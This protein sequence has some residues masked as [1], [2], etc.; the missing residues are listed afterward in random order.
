[1]T[2]NSHDRVTRMIRLS[3]PPEDVWRAI[4]DFDGMAGWH[5]VFAASEPAEVDGERYRRLTTAEGEQ[6]FERLIEAGPL[7]YAYE[8]VEGPMPVSDCRATLAC[9]AEQGGGCH[10]FWSARFEPPEGREREA[11]EIVGAL[12]EIG[13][14]ALPGRFA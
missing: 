14:A 12:F 11:D 4:G 6:Y 13:L 2:D 10:V 1:M 3:A 7:R 5:P 8:M 9:V